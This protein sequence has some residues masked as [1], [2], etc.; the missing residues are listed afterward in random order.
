MST[1]T[2]TITGSTITGN[3]I[4]ADKIEN[5]F[6]QLTSSPT[7]GNIKQLLQKQPIEITALSQDLPNTKKT[8]VKNY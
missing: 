5:S 2:V 7:S 6:N 3:V 4:A 1:Q 8:G